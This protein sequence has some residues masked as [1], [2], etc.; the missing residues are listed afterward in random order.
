MNPHDK[1][2]YGEDAPEPPLVSLD[3]QNPPKLPIGHPDATAG[4]LEAFRTLV[5]K[6]REL[7]CQLATT[8]T[9]S[10]SEGEIFDGV[11]GGLYEMWKLLNPAAELP[12]P[13]PEKGSMAD[14]AN[15]LL[16]IHVELKEKADG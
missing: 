5:D 9:L 10:D 2:Y 1:V 13:E 8:V 14:L 16:A 12:D 3:P 6:A 11:S 15:R 4:V 7:M